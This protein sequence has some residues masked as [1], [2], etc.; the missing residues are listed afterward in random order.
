MYKSLTC[1]ALA[2]LL[3]CGREPDVSIRPLTPNTN[4]L[5][6]AISIVS[7]EIIWV[8]GHRSTFC[9]TL[10]G[11]ENWETFTHPMIDSLQFRDIHAFD[12]E[13]I[14]LMSA[15]SGSLSR[16]F[17]FHAPTN[18]LEEVY[19]MPHPEGFL[20]T[21]E[22]W[23]DTLGLAFGDSFQGQ[24]FL[25]KS[26]DAGHSWSRVDPVLLPNA[27]EG[28]G[29]FAASGT[30]ISMLPDGRAWIATGA[31]GHSNILYTSDFGASWSATESP[32][33]KGSA[34]GITSIRISG[35]GE[36]IIVGGDLAQPD[37]YTSNTAFTESFGASWQLRGFPVTLGAFYGA[38]VVTWKGKS[39]AFAC[40]PNGLDYTADGGS[41]W[42]NLDTANYWAVAFHP[43][44]VGIATGKEGRISKIEL[45]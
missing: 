32:L 39:I 25:L 10:D 31:G 16:L 23:N 4:N 36:G 38:A 18:N 20:N 14:V 41:R 27:G 19:Q 13:T 11:G 28:E 43:N 29:G 24:H 45:K 40:G 33:I 35:S 26:A 1:L 21:I 17:R 15:G 7:P 12:E 9:R 34:A 6:Q 22:F 42:E 8:S 3:S 30:C 5:L 2:V 37:V 44:G